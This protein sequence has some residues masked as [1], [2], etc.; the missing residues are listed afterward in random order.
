[1]SGGTTIKLVVWRDGERK[2]ITV[3]LGK[4]PSSEELAGTLPAETTEELGFTVE[5]LTDELAERYGY[6]SQ[7]GVIVSSVESGSQ[8]ERV[9]IVPGSLIKEVDQQEVKNTKEFNE[10][11]KK[12]RKKGSVLLLIKRGR[13]TFF[14]LLEM[15]EK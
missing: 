4:R 3:E 12:A 8:A 6:E 10:A 15:S 14:A 9:G 2:N 11:I 5:T 7:S 13:Y 1:L